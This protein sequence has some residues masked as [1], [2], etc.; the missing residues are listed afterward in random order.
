MEGRR[1]FSARFTLRES[2]AAPEDHKLPW[3]VIWGI[4]LLI[5][6]LVA[7]V[8]FVMVMADLFLLNWKFR[9]TQEAISST[10]LGESLLVLMGISALFSAVAGGLVIFFAPS[11]AG[12]GIPEAK[13]Y[14]N[15]NEVPDFLEVRSLL[16][17]WWPWCW[18]S[19]RDF[20]W[21]VK[22]RCFA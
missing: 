3:Y 9:V 15:G 6:V 21:D 13:G 16:Y 8:N 19:R 20:R 5:P 12:S 2:H 22:V 4:T 11:C 18:P 1:A 14:L 7:L 10:S 17:A